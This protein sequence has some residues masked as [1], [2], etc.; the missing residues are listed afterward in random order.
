MF[1]PALIQAR[2]SFSPPV[3]VEDDSIDPSLY[4]NAVRWWT[5]DSLAFSDGAAV[6]S[7]VDQIGGTHA[8]TASSTARPTYKQGSGIYNGVLPVLRFDGSNDA[9]TGTDAGLP[10]GDRTIVAVVKSSATYA[11]DT[12]GA[13]MHYGT[14]AIG[15][16]FGMTFVTAAPT[17]A[18]NSAGWVT[19]GASRGIGSNTG[20]WIVLVIKKTGSTWQTFVN[21]DQ[22][23]VHTQAA[24]TVLGGTLSVGDFVGGGG[25]LGG[26]LRHLIIYDELLTTAN[27]NDLIDDLMTEGETPASLYVTTGGDDGTGARGNVALPFATI[28]AALDVSAAASIWLRTCGSDT[29]NIGA[30]AFVPVTGSKFL[31]RT[32]FQGAGKPAVDDAGTPTA[33]IGGTRIRGPFVC[34]DRSDIKV[35]DLGVDSGSAVCTTHYG[36]TAQEALLICAGGGHVAVAFNPAKPGCEAARITTLAKTAGSAVHSML[37]ENQLAPT[38]EDIDTYYGFGGFITKTTNGMFHN[39]NAH[40]HGVDDTGGGLYIKAN[41]YASCSGNTYE[42]VTIT[43]GRGVNLVTEDS[44]STLSNITIDGLAVTNAESGIA[45]K[46]SLSGDGVLGITVSNFTISGTSAVDGIRLS[47]C[48]GVTLSTGT[49]ST[50]AGDGIEV[51][52]TAANTTLTAI[53]A[54]SNGGYGVNNLST[55]TAGSGQVTGSG[56]GSGLLGGNALL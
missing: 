19:Y 24:T 48:S 28:D 9:L 49:V 35:F 46:I 25:P 44:G 42:D 54:N 21:R 40:F 30:G 17:V 33:L 53:V 38:A 45:R 52:S 6:G 1:C 16:S 11:Q 27:L 41:A 22:G 2:G 56:N 47:D 20:G 10:T 5:P 39:I 32:T 37:M 13:I 12:Y 14:A 51:A 26:D 7:L 36:G 55:T 34:V 31:S 8:L 23:V 3:A 50:S 43:G 29:I 4:G 15:A 18:A